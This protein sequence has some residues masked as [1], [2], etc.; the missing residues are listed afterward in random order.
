MDED[1]LS[2]DRMRQKRD[3][4]C[5]DF[6]QERVTRYSNQSITLSRKLRLTRESRFTVTCNTID[7]IGTY[8]ARNAT[9]YMCK[10]R[11]GSK[12]VC[13]VLPSRETAYN[14]QC[15]CLSINFEISRYLG[16]V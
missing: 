5:Q 10:G 14:F 6:R 11:L 9:G 1:W 8:V 12:H 13:I 7:L 4:L 3:R 15:L 2:S 16:L